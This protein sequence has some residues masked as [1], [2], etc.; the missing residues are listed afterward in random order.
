MTE[1]CRIIT[2]VK[3]P[4]EVLEAF[5]KKHSVTREEALAALVFVPGTKPSDE[6]LQKIM[7]EYDATREEAE[8]IYKME[9]GVM[10]TDLRELTPEGD[11]I[12]RDE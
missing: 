9:H 10:D 2:T 1:R 11:L 7:S 3:P 8:E 4:R 5:M 12:V 6:E